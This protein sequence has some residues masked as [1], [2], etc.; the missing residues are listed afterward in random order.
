MFI[1]LCLKRFSLRRI[2][3]DFLLWSIPLIIV[4][5]D[6]DA[7]FRSWLWSTVPLSR[8][9]HW[10]SWKALRQVVYNWPHKLFLYILHN[11]APGPTVDNVILYVYLYV[12][13]KCVKTPIMLRLSCGKDTIMRRVFNGKV[14]IMLHSFNDKV[15]IIHSEFKG[16]VPI[17]L[18]EFTGIA[19]ITEYIFRVFQLKNV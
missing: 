19:S 16:K 18:N 1:I 3:K 15:P 7:V 8:L 4:S 11:E 14:L 2:I 13:I 6:S 9:Y 10:A 5:I 17:V 12:N